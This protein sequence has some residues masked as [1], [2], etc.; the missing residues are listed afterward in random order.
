LVRR[1]AFL[2]LNLSLDILNSVRRLHL[3]GDGLASKSLHK[4]LHPASQSEDQVQSTL[5]LDVVVGQG[6]PVFQ[7]LA[8][9]DET[10]LVRG[11]AFLVLNL[12]L[13][14]LDGVRRLHLEG[15]GL[16]SEGLH[17]Y[18]HPSSQPQDQVESALLLDVVV[19]QGAP[20]LQLLPSKDET[21]LV[22]R[23]AFLI[24]NLSLDILNSVRRLHLQGDGLA[25]KSLHKDLHPAS[26]SE[27]QVQS[28]LLLDV[29]VGQGAPVFQLLASKD[30]TLLVRGNAFLVLN[31]GLHILDGVRRLHLEGD[32]LAS[33]S[34]HKDL[35]P[36]TKP[37]DKVQS[38]FLLDVVVGQGAPVLQLLAGKD[39]TLLVRGNAF[40][41]LDLSL[42]I[43]DGIRR[44]HFQGDRLPSQGFHKDLHLV[45]AS[46]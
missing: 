29:V 4:D 46:R 10:L 9:K 17:E 27:D 37:K 1:D 8:S 44:L 5:L 20:V 30:E 32:G 3:Q 2:I 45:P 39:E 34:L 19:R 12:G 7:L 13:H 23:D 43:L 11:N 18:L 6:A 33:Q 22:R 40:L 28:T 24:L 15:D 41:V 35:H 16:A 38:A 26:Q 42:H 14:I 21:L 25:S 36:S 31:L